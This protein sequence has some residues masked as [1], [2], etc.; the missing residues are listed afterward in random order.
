VAWCA[1]GFDAVVADPQRVVGMVERHLCPGA[2]VLMHEGAP[3]GRNLEGMAL[4]L[5][6]LEALGYRTL[7]P[8][9]LEAAATVATTQRAA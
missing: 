7:L 1:R 4:L 5:Q 8:E 2:I 3:H 6:R 9:E